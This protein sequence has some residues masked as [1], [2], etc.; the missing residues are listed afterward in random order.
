MRSPYVACTWGL[1][2]ALLYICMTL[3]LWKSIYYA[4]IRFHFQDVW[5]DWLDKKVC[6]HFRLT[7]TVRWSK[8]KKMMKQEGQA[9]TDY[10]FYIYNEALQ[11]SSLVTNKKKKELTSRK[12][13]YP[14]LNIW[15]VFCFR[16]MDNHCEFCLESLFALLHWWIFIIKQPSIP[17]LPN[18]PSHDH[19]YLHVEG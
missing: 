4:L 7:T 19:N 13:I 14:C 6:C 1:P 2:S 3:F 5:H 16:S 8:L 11:K 17:L 15:Y 18:A 10:N 9:P 12:R